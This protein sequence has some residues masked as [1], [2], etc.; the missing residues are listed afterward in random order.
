VAFRLL[1]YKYRVVF[2]LKRTEK[3]LIDGWDVK[4]EENWGKVNREDLF[5]SRSHTKILL[6]PI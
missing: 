4:I 3:M 1:D 2:K 6:S 5:S